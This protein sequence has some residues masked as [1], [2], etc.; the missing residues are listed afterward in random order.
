[1]KNESVRSRVG[2]WVQVRSKAEIL[3]TLDSNG[4]LDGMPFMPEMFAFCGQSFRIYKSAHK[5]C[6]TVFP[7]RG[8]R[9]KDAIHL[10]TRCD[11]S[12]HGGC[13][14]GCLLFWKKA[15][16]KTVDTDSL[17]GSSGESHASGLTEADLLVQCQVRDPQSGE[18]RYVCQ[19]TQLPYA[20]NDLAWWDVRQ[21]VED[22]R[23]GNA[24]LWQVFCGAVYFFFYSLSRAGIGLGRPVRWSY[25]KLHA[26]W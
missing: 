19:A 1:M 8:R 11:G 22:Y 26:L 18:P 10:E 3:S 7:V 20:T 2:E 4:C 15:W 17:K 16:L 25:D 23:S 12:I 13:Q 21:Y 24:T 14:A 5:T 9:V 6:D